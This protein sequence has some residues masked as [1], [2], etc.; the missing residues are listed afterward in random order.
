MSGINKLYI[1]EA[2]LAYS[3]V[4]NNRTIEQAL[5]FGRIAPPSYGVFMKMLN[6]CNR[7]MENDTHPW[8]GW[9]RPMHS[10]SC[11]PIQCTRDHDNHFNLPRELWYDQTTWALGRF[12]E[13]S[14][15]VKVV[16]TPEEIS[17]LQIGVTDLESRTTR[18]CVPLRSEGYTTGVHFELHEVTARSVSYVDRSILLRHKLAEYPEVG[19][20][21]SIALTD[22]IPLVLLP[23]LRSTEIIR[24][25]TTYPHLI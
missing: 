2:N 8:P 7:I 13:N 4:F 23:G 9:Y 11:R 25:L 18:V 22:M 16:Q 10:A 20:L 5:G 12:L 14:D 6:E 19:L 1:P 15:V 21:E 3:D 17:V 24:R